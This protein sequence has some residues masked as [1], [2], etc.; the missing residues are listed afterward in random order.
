MSKLEKKCSA[1]VASGTTYCGHFV[2]VHS[3]LLKQNTREAAFEA[4]SRDEA[5][6]YWTRLQRVNG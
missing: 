4:F 3:S 6:V 2:V 1:S 5:R